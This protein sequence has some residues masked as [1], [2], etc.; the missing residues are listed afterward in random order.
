MMTELLYCQSRKQ[1]AY[2][3]AM[4]GKAYP[5]VGLCPTH[6]SVEGAVLECIDLEDGFQA[7]TE[8]WYVYFS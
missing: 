5:V 1:F 4:I 6:N 3:A 7:H 8:P 2:Q